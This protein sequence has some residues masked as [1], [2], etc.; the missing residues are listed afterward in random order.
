MQSDGQETSKD[1]RVLHQLFKS[2]FN[3][4]DVSALTDLYE[5][6]AVLV[7]PDGNLARGQAEIRQA[8]EQL[9]TAAPRLDLATR[10]VRVSGDLALMSNEWTMAVG[11]Q[12]GTTLS[13]TTAEVARLGEDGIWR[14]VLDEPGF[15]DNS[16]AG[17]GENDA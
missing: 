3:E 12:P 7:L 4:G 9:L 8:Y 1:P 15:A 11:G 10:R 13:G 2:R 17:V 16:H 14:Y 6:D 5:V